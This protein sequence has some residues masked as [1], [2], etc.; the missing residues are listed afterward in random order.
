[1]SL[2]NTLFGKNPLS[3][4]LLAMLGLET[5]QWPVGRFRDI[6]V[7]KDEESGE[8]LIVLFTR[9][10]GGN[11]EHWDDDKPEGEDCD[12]PGCIIQHRLPKHPMYVRDYDDD[13]D[14]TYAS[15]DFKVPEFYREIVKDMVASK[16]P[17]EKFGELIN[18]MQSGDT[19]DPAVKEAM[20]KTAPIFE[21]LKKAMDG[22]GPRIVEV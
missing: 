3:G 17:M 18:K 9:N 20:E 4:A 13:F 16:T 10:G 7:K 1:M 14:S 21:K 12:C 5:E 8:I 19:D 6:Y 15:I 11:R 2:Y 22:N